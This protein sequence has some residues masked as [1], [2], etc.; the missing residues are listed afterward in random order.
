MTALFHHLYSSDD[1]VQV[2]LVTLQMLIL[3]L[4]TAGTIFDQHDAYIH[5][6]IY[7]NEWTRKLTLGEMVEARLQLIPTN[8]LFTLNRR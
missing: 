1:I 2:V 6:K 3:L 4:S 7:I 8:E 5:A